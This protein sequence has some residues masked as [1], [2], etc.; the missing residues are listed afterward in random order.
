MSSQ[1]KRARFRAPRSRGGRVLLNLVITLVL[2][3]LLFYVSL[4][5]INLKAPEFYSFFITLCIIYMV[6]ALVTSGFRAD[7]DETM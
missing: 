3:A 4:P 6:S 2:G 7:S 1:G 5:P